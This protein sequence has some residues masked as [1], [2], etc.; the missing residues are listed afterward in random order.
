MQD[1]PQPST[2]NIA[3]ACALIAGVTGYFIGQAKSIGL[4]GGSPISTPSGKAKK[5]PES[6]S[7]DEDDDSKPNEFPGH[8]DDCKLVLVV[9]TDLGMTK[10]TFRSHI[11]A[12]NVYSNFFNSRQDR[13]TVWPCNACVLQAL[14][15]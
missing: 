3:I 6:D 15:A 7:S 14:Y 12:A 5:A 13:G 4:F 1:T 8:A 9:R 11:G 2:A 10:G